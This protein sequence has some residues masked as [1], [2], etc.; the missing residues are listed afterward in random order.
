MWWTSPPWIC[1]NSTYDIDELDGRGHGLSQKK[2]LYVWQFLFYQHV[3][4]IDQIDQFYFWSQAFLP[5]GDEYDNVDLFAGRRAIAKA[6]SRKSLKATA[7]DIIIDIRDATRFNIWILW[8]LDILSL[9]VCLV[10]G[11]TRDRKLVRTNERVLK[12][13]EDFLWSMY[14]IQRI[15]VWS[16]YRLLQLSI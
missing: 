4:I 10:F 15:Y 3:L 7:M 2:M 12:Y 14:P 9:C 11:D 8:T 13:T 16:K 6:Y 1:S 5:P